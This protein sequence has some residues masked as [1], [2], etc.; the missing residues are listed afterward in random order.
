MRQ[1]DGVPALVA[2]TNCLHRGSARHSTAHAAAV[3]DNPYRPCGAV[4]RRGQNDGALPAAVFVKWAGHALM[5][6][7]HSCAPVTPFHGRQAPAAGTA[8]GT[9]V[10]DCRCLTAAAQRVPATD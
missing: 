1:G 4:Y 5:S 9:A 2:N 3:P 10:G 8:A 7:R 6:W